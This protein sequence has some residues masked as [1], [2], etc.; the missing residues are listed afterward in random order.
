[1]KKL[2]YIGQCENG[3]TSRM[4]FEKLKIFFGSEIELIDLTPIIQNTP[5]FYRSLGWR[6]KFGRLI[7]SINNSISL[8]IKGNFYDLVWIDKGVFIRPEVI[9]QLRSKTTKL[10][11]FT[12]DPAFLYHRSRFF[13]ASIGYFD[14][15]ITTKSFEIEIYKS[16][17]AIN[18]LYMTQG[19]DKDIHRPL[20]D[21]KNKKYEVCFIGHY[22]KERAELIQL[23]LDNGIEVV[24]AGIKWKQFVRKN[25][26]KKLRYF[27]KHVAGNEYSKLIS[28]SYLGLGL[29]SKWIPE[30]HTTRT[31]EIPACCTCLVTEVT[32]EVIEFF[33][34]DEC[35]KFQNNLECVQQIKLILKNQLLLKEISQKGYNRVNKDRRD[36]QNQIDDICNYIITEI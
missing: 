36:Y 7:K 6:F 16:N 10:V 20:T 32:E 29:L 8:K 17:G 21:F 26:D 15:C 19:F 11:H 22:E 14:L 2:L 30:R 3:S 35:L 25:R 5:R 4:R 1:M 12:P 18:C 9:K 23:L 27:G 34:D 31:F 33:N 28:E 24:L 13:K